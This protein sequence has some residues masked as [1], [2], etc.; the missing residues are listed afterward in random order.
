MSD[1]QLRV[2]D[3]TLRDGEQAP[4]FS[5]RPDEKLQVAHQL[6]RLGECKIQK[7]RM[8]EISVEELGLVDAVRTA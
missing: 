6:A 1:V 3:T 7:F 4:G 5:L 2:F 8:R